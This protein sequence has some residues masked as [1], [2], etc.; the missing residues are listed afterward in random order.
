M[1]GTWAPHRLQKTRND[2][3]ICD[4]VH[5]KTRSGTR[6]AA[7]FNAPTYVFEPS[8]VVGQ[9]LHAPRHKLPNYLG[10]GGLA[11]GYGAGL[12][13]THKAGMPSVSYL[14]DHLSDTYFR[15][16]GIRMA[17][18]CSPIYIE[19]S[20]VMPPMTFPI[21]IVILWVHLSIAILC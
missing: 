10:L 19:F 17:I 16:T 13:M 9:L 3:R 5:K 7:E 21:S 8:L 12:A 14:W 18:A 11:V 20:D 15:E 6:H 4:F 2:L 1:A